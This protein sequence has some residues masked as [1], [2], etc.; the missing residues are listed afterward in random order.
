MNDA[1][2]LRNESSMTSARLFWATTLIVGVVFFIT[3]H[4][5]SLSA[6]NEWSAAEDWAEGVEGGFNQ[7]AKMLAL[8]AI[9]L[10]GAFL[11]FRAGRYSLRL[12]DWLTAAILA[13]VAMG[14]MSLTWSIHASLTLRRIALATFWCMAALGVA[15]QFTMR[16]ILRMALATSFGFLAI[17]L[18]NE[19]LHGAFQPFNSEY[20]FAGTVHPNTQGINCAMMCMAAVGMAAGNPRWRNI[21]LGMAVLGLVFM[22][23]TKSRMSV[24]ALMV[25]GGAVFMMRCSLRTVLT[26]SFFGIATGCLLLL[27]M[28]SAGQDSVG[29]M[30]Q[31]VSLGREKEM[32]SFS[33]RLPLWTELE[34]YIA[35]RPMLGYGYRAFWDY[36]HTSEIGDALGGWQAPHAHSAYFDTAL[37]FGVPAAIVF[38]LAGLFAAFRAGGLFWKS[39]DSDCGFAFA[40]IVYALFDSILESN[41]VIPNIVLFVSVC[42]AF[43]LALSKNELD[44]A[45]PRLVQARRRSR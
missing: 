13:Y 1:I 42:A 10:F 18:A 39:S 36:R 35:K 22:L 32:E 5:L 9:G 34:G 33:G 30:K 41:F 8:P 43:H 45:S 44:D 24:A 37:D 28:Q 17:G 12:D 29:D 21:F 31:F 2:P 19:I 26:V 25:A 7:S 15:R 4:N 6:Q 20:R 16:E 23:L 3:T 38:A 40:M 11:L 14:M 27:V